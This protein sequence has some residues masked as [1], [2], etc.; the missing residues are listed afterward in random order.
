M[1][2]GSELEFTAGLQG[3][4]GWHLRSRGEP[5]TGSVKEAV[6]ERMAESYRER[7]VL[8]AEQRGMQV[9]IG[10]HWHATAVSLGFQGNLKIR[11]G[12]IKRMW[13]KL[14]TRSEIRRKFY[15]MERFTATQKRGRCRHGCGCTETAW[16]AIAECEKA[17]NSQNRQRFFE[18]YQRA[19]EGKGCE[20]GEIVRELRKRLLVRRNGSFRST[21]RVDRRAVECVVFGFV[22]GWLSEEATRHTKDEDEYDQWLRRHGRFMKKWFWQ[23]WRDF[24]G[25]ASVEEGEEN[26]GS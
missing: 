16:H 22:P 3:V 21:A 9:P 7:Y 8:E 4:E 25:T 6:E 10:V 24:K 20:I 26:D 18:A 12:N 14:L 19:T 11:A 23:Q 1:A 17:G 5:A 2:Y 15:R 13:R